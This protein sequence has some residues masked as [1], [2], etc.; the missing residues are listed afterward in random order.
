[1]SNRPDNCRAPGM[2][3]CRALC[4]RGTGNVPVPYSY[5]ERS[6]PICK[7]LSP[8]QTTQRGRAVL[9]LRALT[10]FFRLSVLNLR[11]P[12]LHALTA[13]KH[14]PF[15]SASAV[16][17]PISASSPTP[18]LKITAKRKGAKHQ[19]LPVPSTGAPES[20]H[21]FQPPER[22]WMLW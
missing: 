11:R 6:A 10:L 1:M 22:E 5:N 17:T 14:C 15:V 3:L 20:S 8:N 2:S 9:Q 19:S 7:L 13:S 4:M 21:T 12:R 18:P 16:C